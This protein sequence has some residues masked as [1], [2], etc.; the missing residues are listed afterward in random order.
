MIYHLE[1]AA[2]TP[3][4][5]GIMVTLQWLAS[6][7]VTGRIADLTNAFGQARKTSRKNKLATKLPPGVTHP[8][9]GPGQLLRVET[10]IYGLVS[11]PS[12]LRASMTVDMLAAGY[13][14]NPYDKCLFTLFSSDETS[15]GQLLLDVDDFKEGGKETH[16]KTMED[17]MTSTVVVR[18]STS[19][20]QDKRVHGFL[21]DVSCKTQISASLCRWTNMSKGYLSNTKEMSDGML[22]NIKG[23]NGGLGWLAS[24]ARPDMAAPHSIIPSG[25]DRRSPQLI[26]EVNA[27][28]KQCHAVPITITIWPIPF[29]ELRWTTFTSSGFDTGERQRHQQGWLVCATN[30]Y[31][32]QE[33]SAPVSVL[34]WRSRKLT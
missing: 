21:E 31:F 1:R 10:E 15:E 29:A 32:N 34:H 2:P 9:V 3:T 18:R 13:V 6:A 16:C 26:S 24:T 7:N 8:K 33:R 12:W 4:Q 23:V 14:K 22:T 20:R 25:Y 30:K 19:C 27:A 5:E 11:G 17:S 28:V